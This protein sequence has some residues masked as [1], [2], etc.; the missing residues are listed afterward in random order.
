MEATNRAELLTCKKLLHK[1]VAPNTLKLSDLITDTQRLCAL[2]DCC[3]DMAILIEHM[4]D[5]GVEAKP[6]D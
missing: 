1:A 4:L 3:L 2:Q 5:T 6:G